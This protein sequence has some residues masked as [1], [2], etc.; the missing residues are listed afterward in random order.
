M[1]VIEL[2]EA[3][4]GSLG[5]FFGVFI[6]IMNNPVHLS[7]KMELS[8]QPGR[9]P[10]HLSGNMKLSDQLGKKPAHLSGKKK[11]SEQAGRKPAHLI[12]KMELSEQRT[13]KPAHSYEKFSTNGQ[14]MSQSQYSIKFLCLYRR[15]VALL[16]VFPLYFAILLEDNCQV[17]L[18]TWS[19]FTSCCRTSI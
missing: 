10:A 14:A 9:K 6:F 3:R 7:G 19:S 5:A 13:K 2:S 15:T 8:E 17:E 4:P 18:R 16:K 11:L 1:K 12:G